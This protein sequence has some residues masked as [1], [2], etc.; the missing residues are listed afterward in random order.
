MDGHHDPKRR[1]APQRDTA[2]PSPLAEL[3]SL[4]ANGVGTELWRRVLGAGGLPLAPRR[5]LPARSPAL[6]AGVPTRRP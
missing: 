5:F 3:L 2:V 1:Q 6:A 4:G